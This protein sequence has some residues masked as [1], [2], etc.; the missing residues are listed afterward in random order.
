[1]LGPALLK[2]Q[3]QHCSR[4]SSPLDTTTDRTSE[5]CLMPGGKF[6]GTLLAWFT[7]AKTTSCSRM[8]VA[9]L[10]G[11]VFF[12]QHPQHLLTALRARIRT[13]NNVAKRC[14]AHAST[15]FH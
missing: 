3:R 15:R 7:V 5:S 14:G 9:R 8:R 2:H 1:M 13:C 11:L 10:A 12:R 4:C 6:Q